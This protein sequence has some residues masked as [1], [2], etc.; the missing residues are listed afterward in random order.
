MTH[1]QIQQRK[2]ENER[3]VLRQVRKA[4]KRGALF[5]FWYGHGLNGNARERALSNALERLIEKGKVV[6][7]R[8]R[9]RYGVG[10]RLS[11]ARAPKSGWKVSDHFGRLPGDTY[12]HG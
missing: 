9:N 12:Y 6:C 8:R 10:Y 3:H 1:Q 4:N 2:R 5:R 11:D 7:I